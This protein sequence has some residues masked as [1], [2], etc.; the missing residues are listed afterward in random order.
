MGEDDTSR[1]TERPYLTIDFVR[2]S[3]TKRAVIVARNKDKPVTFD[4]EETKKL[5]L[6]IEIDGKSKEYTPNCESMINFQNAW[7]MGSNGWIGKMI[8]LNIQR[9]KGKEYISAVPSYLQAAD[10]ASAVSVPQID[11]QKL[12]QAA[13]QAMGVPPESVPVI[14][15]QKLAQEVAA[16]KKDIPGLQQPGTA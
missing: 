6:Q 4:G 12:T 9:L 5:S 7:G 10:Q 11:M 15:M 3:P 14:D 8:N 16:V 13:A 2:T 1:Y